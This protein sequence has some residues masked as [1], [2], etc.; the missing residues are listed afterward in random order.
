MVAQ[1]AFNN[2]RPHC[3]EARTHN[4]PLCAMAIYKT[5]ELIPLHI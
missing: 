3:L 4:M 1:F 5:P 2:V